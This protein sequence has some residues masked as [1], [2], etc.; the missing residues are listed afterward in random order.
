MGR[1]VTVIEM[2]ERLVANASGIHTT[3][4]VDHMDKAGIRSLVNTKCG[5]IRQEDSLPANQDNIKK[6]VKKHK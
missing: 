2:V 4:L 5:K 3:G 6:L 1:E